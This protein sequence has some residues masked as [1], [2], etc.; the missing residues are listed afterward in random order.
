MFCGIPSLFTL[1]GTTKNVARHSLV[2]EIQGGF[3]A[4]HRVSTGIQV[5]KRSPEQRIKVLRLL[6]D[7]GANFHSQE[8]KVRKLLH[9]FEFVVFDCFCMFSIEK[10]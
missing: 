5:N 1:F 2:V 10:Y 8:L 7:S 4:L 3:T 9:A 6:L